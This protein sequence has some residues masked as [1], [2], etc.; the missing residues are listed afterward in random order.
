MSYYLD[1]LNPQSWD[2]ETLCEIIQDP[3]PITLPNQIIKQRAATYIGVIDSNKNNRKQ[4][5]KLSAK[6]FKIKNSSIKAEKL[7]K[8]QITKQIIYVYNLKQKR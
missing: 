5:K 2:L 7:L 1:T 4:R 8:H 3:D 6:T